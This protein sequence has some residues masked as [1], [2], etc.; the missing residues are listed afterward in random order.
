MTARLTPSSGQR[1][2]KLVNAPGGLTLL[3][4][5]AAADRQLQ[6]IRDRGLEE[7]RASAA[8]MVTLGKSL[9]VTRDAAAELEL[10]TLSNGLVGV[11]AVFGLAELGEVAFSLCTLLDRF[12]MSGQF[13]AQAIQIHLDSVRLLLSDDAQLHD[14]GAI[15]AALRQVVDRVD[16]GDTAKIKVAVL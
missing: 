15:G 5:V 1:L 12:S 7:I 6:T 8:R 13:S 4:A 11:A 9:A 14:S 2:A 10:Y 16:A 3:E